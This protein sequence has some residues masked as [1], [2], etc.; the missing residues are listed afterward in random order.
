M[1]CLSEC[2][3]NGNLHDRANQVGG[4]V[5]GPSAE[6]GETVVS[7]SVSIDRYTSTVT[8]LLL[9]SRYMYYP[10]YASNLLQYTQKARWPRTAWPPSEPCARVTARAPHLVRHGSPHHLLPDSMVAFGSTAGLGRSKASRP[11]LIRLHH[12]IPLR[13][14]P[15]ARPR[16]V[17][18]GLHIPPPDG[19][20]AT[21]RSNFK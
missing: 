2:P 11:G 6:K 5:V 4:S 19:A 17:R 9:P 13:T 7:D 14:P 18:L 3:Q 1:I 12:Q 16:T 8:L 20:T 10:L 15:S 21:P